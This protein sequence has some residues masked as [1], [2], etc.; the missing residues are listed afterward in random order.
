M[1]CMGITFLL[2]WCAEKTTFLLGA[3]PAVQW[4]RLHTPNGGGTGSVPGQG[5]NIL[6]I[7]KVLKKITSVGICAKN[8]KPQSN[9]G[10][11]PDTPRMRNI[12]QS[13][14]PLL[15]KSAVI[16][17]D[18]AWGNVPDWR[19]LRR[20]DNSAPCV[21]LHGILGR[22]RIQ[23]QWTKLENQLKIS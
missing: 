7:N 9:S 8:E 19:R 18:K 5:S 21:R 6:Q 20:H 23:G 13:N 12:L 3:S 4:L 15:F 10:K 22:R 14:W 1:R 2:V 16:R 17:K 11:A